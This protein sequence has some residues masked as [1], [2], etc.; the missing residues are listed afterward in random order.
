M[1]QAKEEKDKMTPEQRKK[2][3]EDLAR[4]FRGAD[5]PKNNPQGNEG[6]KS[7][8]L[9]SMPRSE[10]NTIDL[11]M[12]GNEKKI[13]EGPKKVMIEVKKRMPMMYDKAIRCLNGF[14][15]DH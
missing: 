14:L 4:K 13:T 1:A 10:E 15:G 2:M 8:V 7:E 11:K 9:T 6:K 5:N 12:P 3:A